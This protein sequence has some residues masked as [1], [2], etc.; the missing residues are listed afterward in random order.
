M[1]VETVSNAQTPN[2]IM[3]ALTSINTQIVKSFGIPEYLLGDYRGYVSDTAV[4]TASRIFF[5]VQLKPIFT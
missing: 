3:E 1:D 4:Q 2:Q 5:Q